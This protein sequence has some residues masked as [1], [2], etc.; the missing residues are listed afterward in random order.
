M[1]FQMKDFVSGFTGLFL[2]CMGLFPLLN[3]MGIGPSWFSVP[4]LGAHMFAYLLA[5]AGAYLFVNSLIE[6]AN[7]NA[8]GWT[9]F[10][11][12]VVFFTLGLLQILSKLNVGP[13]WFGMPWVGETTYSIIFMIE[14]IFLMIAMWAMEL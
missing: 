1:V 5:I 11:I 3:R 10:G 13:A 2:F 7:S 8:I 4:S 6:V 9:S 14:G 12:A